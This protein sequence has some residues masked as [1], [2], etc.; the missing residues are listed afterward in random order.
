MSLFANALNVRKYRWLIIELVKREI[1]AKYKQSILGYA[2]VILVPLVHLVVMTVVFSLFIRV[3]T[4][5][6]P[7]PVFLFVALVPWMFTTNAVAAATGSLLSNSQLITKIYLP[8]E[9]FPLSAV[10]S[11]LVDLFL[12]SIVLVIIM[13]YFKVSFPVTIF[14]IFLIFFFQFLLTLGISF[15]LS[16]INVF[17]RDV[18]NMLG[19]FLMVWMYLTPVFYPPELIPAHLTPIFNLNPM[20]GI[21][22]SYRNV[23]LHAALPPGESFLYAAVFSVT[24]FLL[25]FVFFRRRSRYF[26]DT[27]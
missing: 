4:G 10:L 5:G 13:L 16:A 3:P 25:G 7:Y 21:I 15:I 11:K 6:I 27:I 2:W 23:V 18:E 19:V 17:Y 12:S 8:R 26:A 9:I 14:Y 20:M 22:N 24:I 1:K